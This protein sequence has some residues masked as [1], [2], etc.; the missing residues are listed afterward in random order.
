MT[1]V[2]RQP[3]TDAPVSPQ[4]LA[5]E[6]QRGRELADARRL[7]ELERAR[8]EAGHGRARADVATESRLAE[9][10][11]AER[12]ADVRA[13]AELARMYR[14][15]RKSGERT[16]IRSLMAR[17]GE[18]RALRLERLRSRNLVILVPLLIGFGLWS[19]TGVQQGAARLMSVTSHSPVWWVLWGL[20][21]LLIGVVCWIIVVRARLATSGGKLSASAERIGAG[22]LTTSIFL[23]LVAAVPT[24]DGAHAS[25]WAIPGAMFAHAIGPVGAALVAHLIGI[26]DGSISD[27][28]PWHDSDGQ[29]VL[30]LADMDLSVPSVS[31]P[32]VAFVPAV[33][34][35]SEGASGVRPTVVWPVP[36][37]SRTALRVVARPDAVKPAESVV[38]T[39]PRTRDER[40]DDWPRGDRPDASAEP[41]ATGRQGRPNRGVR[42]PPTARQRASASRNRTDEELAARLA[43]LVESGEL[44]PVS[45]RAVERALNVGRDRAK[46]VL[47][48]AGLG[49]GSDAPKADQGGRPLTVVAGG[50]R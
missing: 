30:R 9:L 50:A 37:G 7:D 36:R 33:E 48:L 29:E 23:N 45:V 25:G 4:E 14:E 28:D 38:E 8:A 43:E 15:F 34:S 21:A 3:A 5:R 40:D 6:L 47:E 35:A 16:R 22:C 12:E 2:K 42:V 49:D 27:A 20:E 41:R 13:E 24:G 19:T 32:A 44:E 39:A 10:A 11:R 17:S 18:A 1:I 26:I 46:R 31:A